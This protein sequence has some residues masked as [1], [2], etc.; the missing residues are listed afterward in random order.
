M[1]VLEFRWHVVAYRAPRS[2][3]V[4]RAAFRAPPVV[5]GAGG[6]P[7]D[8]E[9]GIRSDGHTRELGSNPDAHALAEAR[10]DLT[11]SDPIRAI[12]YAMPRRDLVR[13]DRRGV[14]F[15]DKDDSRRR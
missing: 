5:S 4:A 12:F 2:S 13:Q 9:S 14:C 11:R 8:R 15:A 1:L 3:S 7:R 6:N 10:S